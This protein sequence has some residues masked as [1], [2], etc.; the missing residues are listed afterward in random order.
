VEAFR[1][2]K[3]TPSAPFNLLSEWIGLCFFIVLFLSAFAGAAVSVVVVE[4]GPVD[5][6]T[7][8][9]ICFRDRRC[10][11][12]LYMY[13]YIY[14]MYIVCIHNTCFICILFIYMYACMRCAII[15]C[16]YVCEDVREGMMERKKK[17]HLRGSLYYVYHYISPGQGDCRELKLKFT[18]GK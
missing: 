18:C 12:V 16:L 1:S 5:I 9:I 6:F 10:A 2:I 11:V 8:R 17:T 15:L 3:K 14:N 4:Q 13:T 7:Y